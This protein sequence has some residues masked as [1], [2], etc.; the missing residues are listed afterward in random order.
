MDLETFMNTCKFY[1]IPQLITIPLVKLIKSVCSNELIKNILL[2][3]I[4]TAELCAINYEITAA[5]QEIGPMMFAVSTFIVMT[6]WLIRWGGIEACPNV[7]LECMLIE[8]NIRYMGILIIFA[9]MIG[10]YLA[11]KSMHVI[12]ECFHQFKRS[13]VGCSTMFRKNSVLHAFIFE[14]LLTITHRLAIYTI[15]YLKE[16]LK[17]KFI[18][19]VQALVETIF[20]TAVSGFVIIGSFNNPVLGACVRY[21][22]SEIDNY[23]SLLVYW[24]APFCGSLHALYTLHLC[25]QFVTYLVFKSPTRDEKVILKLNDVGYNSL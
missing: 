3:I 1:I 8:R 20:R 22:C 12:W 9:E 7:I 11:F 17:L 6:V 10:G 21:G 14:W 19:T 4:A 13:S 2:E 25:K 16:Y 24:I 5:A 23:E 18:P 15:A